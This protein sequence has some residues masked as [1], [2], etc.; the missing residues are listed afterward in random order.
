MCGK[1]VV[2]LHGTERPLKTELSNFLFMLQITS[3]LRT[4]SK[5]SLQDERK[6]QPFLLAR[7]K[8]IV[9]KDLKESR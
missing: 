3:F 6:V 9:A 2:V 8:V 4:Y 1:T 5:L 7:L